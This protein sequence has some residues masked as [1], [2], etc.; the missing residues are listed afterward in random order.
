MEFSAST[1]PVWVQLR[2][3]PLELQ[4][5]EGLSCIAS[6][7]GKPLHMDQD[8]S[9]LLNSSRINVCVEVDFSKPLLREVPVLLNDEQC[10][11][12]V[13]YPW[14]PQQCQSCG[15]WGHHQLACS[16]PKRSKW[17]PK[18]SFAFVTSEHLTVES[19]PEEVPVV[20]SSNLAVGANIPAL[21]SSVSISKLGASVPQEPVSVFSPSLAPAAA[22]VE[23]P[24]LAVTNVISLPV[25]LISDEH[26]S[27]VAKSKP[28]APAPIPASK[29]T[30]YNLRNTS[31]APSPRQVRPAAAGVADLVKQI[32]PGKKRKSKGKRTALLQVNHSSPE[33]SSA[34]PILPT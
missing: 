30:Q 16:L 29:T 27:T 3:V 4:T 12:G 24:V 26:A 20:P 10:C 14:T 21:T 22:T 25:D 18:T 7:V 2:Q 11:I 34:P 17:V 8:C 13:H 15:V 5:R 1:L 31:D 33:G 28:I 23:P 6:A 32:A 19:P 9:K